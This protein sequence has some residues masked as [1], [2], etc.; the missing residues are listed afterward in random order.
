MDR[1]KAHVSVLDDTIHRSAIAGE[2]VLANDLFSWFAFDIMGLFAF[3]KTFGMLENEEWHRAA[4]QLRRGMGALGVLSCIPWLA[5]I[6][7]AYIPGLWIV[8]DWFQM[9][10]FCH[11]RM[12]ERIDMKDSVDIASHMI[13]A[14][15]ENGL[16]E[17]DQHW[18]S[19]DGLTLI[20]GGRYVRVAIYSNIQMMLGLTSIVIRRLQRSPFSFTN[21][22]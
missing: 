16:T 4:L 3:G 1:I 21:S 2:P 14:A 22:H 17:E 5:R 10:Q 15:K 9:R 6:G 20:V 11:E 13:R 8:K 12:K 19:G 7:F 18:L